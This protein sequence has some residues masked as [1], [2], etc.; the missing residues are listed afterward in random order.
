VV[1]A[2][3]RLEPV[4]TVVRINGTATPWHIG[5]VA[6]LAGLPDTVILLPKAA[7]V[8]A[9]EALA[10]HPVIALC[11]TAAG[12]LA[13][14]ALAAASNCVA[15]MWG[16]EDLVADLRGRPWRTPSGAYPPAVEEARNRILYA[17]RAAGVMPIDTVLVDIADLEL[18][19]RDSVAAV[20]SGFTAKACV[21]PSQVV[22]VREA[23]R[24]TPEEIQW[25]REL[26]AAAVPACAVFQFAG[27]MIDAPVLA[28]ASEVL[29]RAESHLHT[30][31]DGWPV[32]GSVLLLWDEV[33]GEYLPRMPSFLDPRHL[34]IMLIQGRRERSVV[35]WESI[36]PVRPT[37]RWRACAYW[38]AR[39]SLPDRQDA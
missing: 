33:I 23:F 28:H 29:R 25:A 39:A 22:V 7:D 16:S 8:A 27:R 12:V 15:L 21:H 6:A 4:R 3:S 31:A 38:S 34:L 26:M 10:P 18:L 20:S 11:E 35:G 32:D 13:A 5:D 24:P 37:C 1:R 36:V 14:P 2:V 17:A 30:A 19:R 9:V